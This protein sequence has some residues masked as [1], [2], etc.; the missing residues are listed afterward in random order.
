M[1]SL[2]LETSYSDIK[3]IKLKAVAKLGE[4]LENSKMHRAQI[5]FGIGRIGIKLIFR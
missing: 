4:N 2:A 3:R 1:H 5:E